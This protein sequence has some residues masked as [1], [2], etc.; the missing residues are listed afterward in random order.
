MLI[1]K[2]KQQDDPFFITVTKWSQVDWDAGFLHIDEMKI[3]LVDIDE[4]DGRS[5][6]GMEKEVYLQLKERPEI[7]ENRPKKRRGTIRSKPA[8]RISKKNKKKFNLRFTPEDFDDYEDEDDDDDNDEDDDDYEDIPKKKKGQ[9]RA[10]RQAKEKEEEE[11]FDDEDDED[12]IEEPEIRKPLER[13]IP[14]GIKTKKTT[15]KKEPEPNL[16]PGEAPK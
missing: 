5:M 1:I 3:K 12:D 2:L 8:G 16:A 15:K 9:S 11:D 6:N 13:K 14:K 7:P 10:E 4:M